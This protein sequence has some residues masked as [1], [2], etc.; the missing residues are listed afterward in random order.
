MGIKNNSDYAAAR[1]VLLLYIGFV[2]I[3]YIWTLNTGRYN[4]D[5]SHQSPELPVVE[6]TFSLVYAIIP[7]LFTFYVYRLSANL[8]VSVHISINVKALGIFLFLLFVTQLF[9]TL[10]Y[11]VG[12]MAL[13]GHYRDRVSIG[14]RIVSLIVNRFDTRIG[15]ALYLLNVKKGDKL[16]YILILLLVILSFARSSLGYIAY[17]PFLIVVCYYN[18]RLLRIIKKFFLPVIIVIVL[19]PR[20]VLYLY[21]IR[22]QLRGM[23]M[24]NDTMEQVVF[25]RLVGRISAFSS[26]SMVIQ[27]RL[28]I[29]SLADRISPWSFLR[30]A[31]F[32]PLPKGQ[33]DYG[34]VLNASFG[35][36][37]F[38]YAI[39]NGVPGSLFISYYHSLQALLIYILTQLTLII[40]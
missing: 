36:F 18:G 1:L 39:I 12:K 40:P 3:S 31:L 30:E 13:G 37:S 22:S 27:K 7:F 6:L 23:D 20:L 11:G 32:I 10:V 14:I 29:I 15:L 5:F 26:S 35:D 4:G 24:I 28:E 38:S 25:G 2:V 16:K 21:N 9:L 19:A 17:L 8:G 34:H 33:L